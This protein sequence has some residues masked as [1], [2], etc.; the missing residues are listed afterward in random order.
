MTAEER[1]M[2]AVDQSGILGSLGDFNNML[3]N[4]SQGMLGVRPGLGMQPKYGIPYEDG[5]GALGVIGGPAGD[6]AYDLYRLFADPTMKAGETGSI[7]R[8]SIPLN[9]VIY[10]D[11]LFKGIQRS[12]TDQPY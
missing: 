10:W 7:V 12:M 6:K 3:E 5:A 4:G 11:G 9:N 8:R 2:A 1:I